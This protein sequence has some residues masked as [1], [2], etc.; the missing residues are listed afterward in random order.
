[1]VVLASLY[2]VFCFKCRYVSWL[3]GILSC[4]MT[5]YTNYLHFQASIKLNA[6]QLLGNAVSSVVGDAISVISILSDQNRYGWLVTLIRQS[7]LHGLT[8]TNAYMVVCVV[9]VLWYYVT[10]RVRVKTPSNTVFGFLKANVVF[11]WLRIYICVG[12]Q[13]YLYVFTEHV[14]ENAMDTSEKGLQ[15]VGTSY[16]SQL[17]NCSVPDFLDNVLRAFFSGGL[18]SPDAIQVFIPTKLLVL[19]VGETL[20]ID[21]M[22]GLKC[23]GVCLVADLVVGNMLMQVR[24]VYHTQQH[25]FAINRQNQKSP[26][27]TI[28]TDIFGVLRWVYTNKSE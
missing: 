19:S 16:W 6:L 26:F 27:R 3:V 21:M 23:V 9:I 20:S 28:R 11:T 14:Y 10:D 24:W 12:L 15:G 7:G 22:R 17:S 2:L 18:A 4:G 1:V 5:M 13:S 8:H 25:L